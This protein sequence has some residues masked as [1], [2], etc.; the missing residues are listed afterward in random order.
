MDLPPRIRPRA[1]TTSSGS[2]LQGH[3]AAPLSTAPDP[4][5]RASGASTGASVDAQRARHPKPTRRGHRTGAR[6]RSIGDRLPRRSLYGRSRDFFFLI[7]RA[8]PAP[9]ARRG[10][11]AA[12]R[13]ARATTSTTPC[14]SSPS[15][16][17]WTISRRGPPARRNLIDVASG[18]RDAHRGLHARQPAQPSTSAYLAAS[19]SV[20]RDHRALARPGASSTFAPMARP[21][22]RP[23]ASPRPAPGGGDFWLRRPLENSYGCIARSIT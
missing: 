22:S 18:E 13:A 19:R 4:H 20:L 5:V 23:P 3:G 11:A 1:P 16:A 15:S 8:A 2:H 17:R 21:R 10:R 12:H 7:E 9:R 14:S 6:C